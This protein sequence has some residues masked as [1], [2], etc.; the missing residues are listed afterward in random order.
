MVPILI[1]DAL[2]FCWRVYKLSS[3]VDAAA[4]LVDDVFGRKTPRPGWANYNRDFNDAILPAYLFSLLIIFFESKKSK[5]AADT[6]F[7]QWAI[8]QRLVPLLP[9][10]IDRASSVGSAATPQAAVDSAMSVIAETYASEMAGAWDDQLVAIISG[11]VQVPIL[12]VLSAELGPGVLTTSA[13]SETIAEHTGL[14]NL[15]VETQLGLLRHAVEDTTKKEKA[16]VRRERTISI[17]DS[18]YARMYLASQRMAP[19]DFTA[20]VK[21]GDTTLSTL[22]YMYV[23]NYALQRVALPAARSFLIPKGRVSSL[24]DDVMADLLLRQGVLIPSADLLPPE[25]EDYDD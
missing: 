21:L 23:N 19:F 11:K 8:K 6:L 17:N 1:T 12:S 22:P 10:I 14:S 9:V 7:I 13:F 20:D 18:L 5:K 25:D 15:A 16:M 3:R 24:S 4:K 2:V